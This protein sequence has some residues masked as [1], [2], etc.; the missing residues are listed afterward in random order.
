MIL[1]K[2][3]AT[4]C[5]S[6][7]IT[8]IDDIFVLVTFFAEAAASK[9]LTP[10][11]ITLGQYLG[12]TVL[13]AVSMIGFGASLLLPAEPIGFL[14][15][16]PILLGI[17]KL[18]ELLGPGDEGEEAEEGQ[19]QGTTRVST[20]AGVKAVLKVSTVT[21]M[22]GGDNIGTYVPLFSQARGLEIAVYVVTFYVLLGL[23]CL[24][25]F[26]VM[27]QRHVMRVAEK[28]ARVFVP[29]L[30]VGLGTYILVKS[31]CYPWTIRRIDR[32]ASSH[33][34]RIIMGVVTAVVVSA[35]IGAMALYRWR[36]R[37]RTADPGETGRG[38]QGTSSRSDQIP[39]TSLSEAYSL[40]VGQAVSQPAAGDPGGRSASQATIPLEDLPE[41]PPAADNDTGEQTRSSRVGEVLAP[42]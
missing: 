38:E 29:F 18:L 32:D 23:W 41:E 15:L 7:A 42:G 39:D 34:G 37:P 40:P 10:L 9:T 13:V 21:V 35:C 33:P 20:A 6:F 36:K 27:R 16:L 19:E 8:N 2:A 12:F 17:W 1:G 25:A 24:A 28:Y 5:S 26:L 30:Y 4:A 31:S 11:K 22:N 14:G 3:I